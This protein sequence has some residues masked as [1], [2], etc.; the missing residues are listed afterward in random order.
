MCATETGGAGRGRLWRTC[1]CR[2]KEGGL[3]ENMTLFYILKL[4]ERNR[5][6]HHSFCPL[7][8]CVCFMQ[9]HKCTNELIHSLLPLHMLLWRVFVFS[10]FLPRILKL[11]VFVISESL[12]S[13]SW[14]EMWWWLT[15]CLLQI[16]GGDLRKKHQRI[17]LHPCQ[18]GES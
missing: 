15:V 4:M 14:C 12:L 6:C 10:F 7:S 17:P 9:T 18:P 16:V 2:K 1:S 8:V 5:H 3:P 13:K 11:R